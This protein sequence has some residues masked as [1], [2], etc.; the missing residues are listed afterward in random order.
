[1]RTY[2][3]NATPDQKLAGVIQTE[4]SASDPAEECGGLLGHHTSGSNA[5]A[6]DLAHL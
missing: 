5:A 1:M 3:G 4:K 2:K 6:V